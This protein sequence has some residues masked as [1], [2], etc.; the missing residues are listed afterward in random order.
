MTSSTA[1][2]NRDDPETGSIRH[3]APAYRRALESQAK[4]PRTVEAYLEALRRLD[5]FLERSDLPRLAALVRGDH[6]KAFVADV[7]RSQSPATALARYRALQSFFRWCEEAGEVERSPMAEMRPPAVSRA[8]A[9]RP[10]A[11]PTIP[12]N[13]LDRLLAACAGRDFRDLRDLAIVRLF[14]DSGLRRNELATL[15]VEDVDL[16]GRSL[17]V[18]G[19]GG[20]TRTVRLT[21]TT[22]RAIERYLRFGRAGHPTRGS[23]A[24]WLGHGGP[25]TG[26]GIYQA[27]EARAAKAGLER[28]G[29]DQLRHAFAQRNRHGARAPVGEVAAAP[30]P[31][32][33]A[34]TV[35]ATVPVIATAPVVAAVPVTATAPVVAVAAVATEPV[36]GASADAR[37]TATEPPPAAPV[38]SAIPAIPEATHPADAGDAQA[39]PDTGHAGRNAAPGTPAP[40]PVFAASTRRRG[41]A[42]VTTLVLVTGLADVASVALFK[43]QLGRRAGVHEV[44]VSAG[45]DGSFL[46]EVVHD[47]GASLPSLVAGVPGFDIQLI[48]EGEGILDV[49]V[50]ERGL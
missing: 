27:I 14:I 50:D 10:D 36:A 19:R 2:A 34:E 29:P 24:L 44:G 17:A 1:P 32:V 37:T 42:R 3:L 25:M 48:A 20:A 40:P 22:G 9:G 11:P 6:L 45:P 33:P 26:N 16:P 43:R 41:P 23:P 47:P 4:S 35:V 8:P 15:R 5:A 30:A 21:P 31:A 49:R 38:P 28:I 46:F 39:P 7:Q 18:A 12:E 13:A